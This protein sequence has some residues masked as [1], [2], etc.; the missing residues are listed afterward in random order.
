[1]LAHRGSDVQAEPLIDACLSHRYNDGN[2]SWCSS[3]SS[4]SRYPCTRGSRVVGKCAH[5]EQSVEPVTW[6]SS[7]SSNGNGVIIENREVADT[8]GRRNNDAASSSGMGGSKITSINQAKCQLK[9]V[10]PNVLSG[11]IIGKNGSNL[12]RIRERTGAFIQANAPGYAVPSK[13]ERFIIVAS[14]SMEACV[15]GVVLML[16]SIEAENKLEL[17]R[18]SGDGCLY[19]KQIIPGG[20]AGSLIGIKG[21]NLERLSEQSSAHIRVDPKPK[22][23]GF[24]PFRTVSYAGS[25][26][27]QLIMG[28]RGVVSCLEEDEQYPEHIK[29]IKSV[30]LKVVAIPEGR[31]G[32]LI[33]PKGL[34]LHSLQQVLRCKLSISKSSSG[35]EMAYY[36]TAWGQPENVKA[37]I[38]IVFLNQAST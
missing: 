18:N 20:C 19:L 31:V 11:C 32:S 34:H 3:G 7:S 35:E 1:M 23:A 17:M 33:G 36:L 27:D 14:D 24:V 9:F 21:Y 6:D 30:A 10:I 26:L 13:R 38:R 37:A 25:T 2:S 4:G 12:E 22:N 5:V 28:L 15:Q 8:N 29:A 16:K